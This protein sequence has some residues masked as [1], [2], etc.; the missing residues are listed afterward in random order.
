MT[1]QQRFLKNSQITWKPSGYDHILK[2]ILRY[3]VRILSG[4][5]ALL[6]LA[7]LLIGGY[8]VL[9][10]QSLIKKAGTALQ[11]RIGG[12]A[13]IGDIDISF[14]RHFPNITLHLTKVSL[15]D[16]LWQQ[17][18]HDLLS[19]ENIFIRFSFFSLFSGHPRV[20]KIF[21]QQGSLYLYTDSTGYTNLNGILNRTQDASPKTP[22]KETLPPGVSL[23]NIR[24][25][26]DNQNN[27]KLFDL[28]IR[29]M[30]CLFTKE[31]RT[32]I[33]KANTDL[34]VNNFI[35]N[36]EKG[37]FLKK[38]SLSGLFNIRYNTASHIVQAEK[39]TLQIGGHPFLIS[40]R[41]FPMYPRTLSPL[42]LKPRVFFTGRRRP[43]SRRRSN[44]N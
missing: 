22:Q 24:F 15:Q 35:L 43:C 28:D 37:S 25:V 38:K 6:L 31:D 4:I 8:A 29:Q 30:D 17:H 11:K 2:K 1:W 16:S 41:L 33:M 13:H 34:T 26:M 36:A 10:R 20:D 40:G 32:L 27:H 42:Q 39:M 44:R 21:L 23:S 12:E 18:H 7:W 19:A 14:F 9:N 3:L 5:I